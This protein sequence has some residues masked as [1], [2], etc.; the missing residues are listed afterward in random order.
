MKTF[1]ASLLLAAAFVSAW[2]Q[3]PGT[4]DSRQVNSRAKAAVETSSDERS[5]RDWGLRQDE[6][7]RFKQLMQGPLGTY[8]P[9]L[10]PLTALGIEART[11]E[12]RRRYA[13][14]QVVV[15]ARRVEKMLAYQRAYDTAWQRLHP[16]MQRVSIPGTKQPKAFAESTPGRIAV[17]VR[18]DCPM[19][20]QRVRQMQAAGTAFDVYMVGSL[21]SDAAIR[22]WASRAGVDPAKVRARTITLNHDAGRWLNIG[23]GGDLPAVVQ[24]VNGQWL[25]Q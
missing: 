21:Q 24:Q 11:D 10:D 18:T 22:Q 15:E 5:P 2:A 17:F 23:M 14:L 12:E 8:S 16:G 6:W 25:R 3:V 13:E 20:D 9:N 4:T 19:C 1:I 7:S